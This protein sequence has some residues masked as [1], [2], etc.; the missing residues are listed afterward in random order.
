M[1]LARFY[2]THKV[3]VVTFSCIYAQSRR[4]TSASISYQGG[5]VFV[6]VGGFV[7]QQYY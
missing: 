5:H 7:C 1:K 2:G 6:P 3:L 4:F